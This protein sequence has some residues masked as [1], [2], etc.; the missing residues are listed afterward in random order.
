MARFWSAAL[1]LCV[2][3]ATPASAWDRGDVDVL[4]VLPDVTPG[5][6]SSVEG[7]T[8]GPDDNIYVP[9]FGFNATGAVGGN[10]VLYVIKPNGNLARKVTIANSSPHPL[11]LA[12]NPATGNLLVLDFGAGKVL[13]VDPMTG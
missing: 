1:V 9:S 12:F 5:V 3:A 11:G 10:A 13:N 7:L 4:A 6:P 2:L 8:V